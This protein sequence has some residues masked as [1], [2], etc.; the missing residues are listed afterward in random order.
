[1]KLI[2]PILI[3]LFLSFTTSF[4]L[5]QDAAD[6][7]AIAAPT[8]AEVTDAEAAAAADPIALLATTDDADLGAIDQLIGWPMSQTTIGQYRL[9]EE[10]DATWTPIAAALRRGNCNFPLPED[11][12]GQIIARL[13]QDEPVGSVRAFADGAG[14]FPPE[15]Q[16]IWNQLMNP[17]NDFNINGLEAGL[18]N[19][20][21]ADLVR[22]ALGVVRS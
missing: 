4:R 1:M 15:C 17:A 2:A 20:P 22:I 3:L 7:A 5:R 8:D 9:W 14:D 21:P 16:A 10:G 11:W 6:Q 19:I 18:R 12:D 13:Q